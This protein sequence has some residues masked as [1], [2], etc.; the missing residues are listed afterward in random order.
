MQNTI[1]VFCDYLSVEL[2]KIEKQPLAQQIEK[3]EKLI[4][5]ADIF[6]VKKILSIGRGS[7]QA[8]E[9]LALRMKIR[10][11]KKTIDEIF[12]NY[13]K[14][15]LDTLKNT[16]QRPRPNSEVINHFKKNYSISNTTSSKYSYPSTNAAL[17]YLIAQV[18]AQQ[19]PEYSKKLFAIAGELS[20]SLIVSGHN[21]PTDIEASRYVVQQIFFKIYTLN[22]QRK[23]NVLQKTY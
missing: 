4:E 13:L 10:L 6:E 20:N 16:H 7:Y 18:T 19:K 11:P 22:N 17:F 5:S 9:Q 12:E 15:L 1:D 14:P 8:F 23:L 3:I 2:N 21:Y